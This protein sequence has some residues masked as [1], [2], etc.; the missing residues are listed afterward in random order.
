VDLLSIFHSGRQL[1]RDY[2]EIEHRFNP[3][4]VGFKNGIYTVL[5]ALIYE[6]HPGFQSLGFRCSDVFHA[7]ITARPDGCI[8]SAMSDLW[9]STPFDTS[10]NNDPSQSLTHQLSSYIAPPTGRPPDIPL[11]LNFERPHNQDPSR[12][13][14]VL[15]SRIG[16][17]LIRYS[18][19]H[20]VL[21]S[22]I[23]S[24]T[25][26]IVSC[27]KRYKQP[28][29]ALICRPLTWLKKRP[30]HRSLQH[31]TYISVKDDKY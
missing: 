11:Y 19:I 31:H 15:A 1:H 4:L 8:F 18:G 6:M 2:N 20:D 27:T 30:M 29:H 3:L 22:L 23:S 5:P 9:R 13:Q 17:E 28:A 25:N 26:K 12:A 21:L 7:N 14:I 16:G 24:L 10:P